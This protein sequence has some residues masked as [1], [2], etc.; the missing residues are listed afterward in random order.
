MKKH[1][2]FIRSTLP[3]VGKLLDIA[4]LRRSIRMALA[5]E[6]V[7]IPCEIC[8]LITT[9]KGIHTINKHLR[10]KDA[11]TD[12]LSF[13]LQELSPGNFTAD[14]SELNRDT[15]CLPLGD[16]VL[17]AQRV[18]DQAVEYGQHINREMAY[19]TIHSVLHL[20][21]YDHLDEGEEKQRMR[22]REEAI[23][24]ACLPEDVSL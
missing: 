16:I 15:G 4:L 11:P 23:L 14:L 13:P 8:V 3:Y 20:L 24:R 5:A 1:K 12:V 10:K 6:Q 21:G 22:G 2:I 19:L 7:D 18:A 17:S 9:D